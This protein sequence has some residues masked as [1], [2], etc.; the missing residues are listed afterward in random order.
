MG[1]NFYWKVRQPDGMEDYLHEDEDRVKALRDALFHVAHGDVLTAAEAQKLLNRTG[2]APE[3]LEVTLPS[4]ASVF[5][6]TEDGDCRIHIGK[7]SAAGLYCY[8]CDETL[9]SAGKDRIHYGDG[10]WYDACPKCGKAKADE[11]LDD[12]A[13]GVEL[14]FAKAKAVRPTGVRSCASFSWAQPAARVIEACRDS[15]EVLVVDEYGQDMTGREFFEM[16]EANCPIRFTDS[17]GS[18]FC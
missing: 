12:N 7:R 3:P 5:S 9:C 17:I 13:A 16:L 4:G 6:D 10:D 18:W 11:S 14:G 2:P 8:D 1:T 15:D